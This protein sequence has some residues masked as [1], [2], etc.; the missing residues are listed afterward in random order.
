MS[1]TQATV[2]DLKEMLKRRGVRE[3]VYLHAD[4][5][6]PWSYRNQ[7]R[8]DINKENADNLAKFVEQTAAVDFARRL[9]LFY[10]AIV[11]YRM[12]TGA[13]CTGVPGDKMSFFMPNP[14]ENALARQAMGSLVNSSSHEIQAHYHHE[15]FVKNTKYT[16]TIEHSPKDRIE[17][18]QNESTPAM[19][20]ARFELG[21]QLLQRRIQEDTGLTFDRWF[22]VHGMWALNASDTDVC[23]ITNEIEIL[24]RNGFA[25]DFTFPAGRAHTNPLQVEPF[26]IRPIDAPKCYDR[27]DAEAEPAACAGQAKSDK[28]FIWASRAKADSCSIDYYSAGVKKRMTDTNQ[29]AKDLVE[30]SNVI[31]GVLYVKTHAHSM[32]PYYFEQARLPVFPHAHPEVQRLLGMILTAAA[33]TNLPIQ[34]LSASETYDK[35]LG[36][37]PRATSSA[38]FGAPR[39]DVSA[40]MASV[41]SAWPDNARARNEFLRDVIMQRVNQVGAVQAGVSEGFL[42]QVD[43]LQALRPYERD[44]VA[45]TVGVAADFPSIYVYKTALGVIPYA[46]ASLGLATTGVE[47]D[48]L[49]LET[50]RVLERAYNALKHPGVPFKVVGGWIG[51]IALPDDV[52]QSLA[53]LGDATAS[54]QPIEQLRKQIKALTEH[55]AVL[56]DAFRFLGRYASTEEHQN[57]RGLFE[58]EGFETPILILGHDQSWAFYLARRRQ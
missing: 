39:V 11:Y 45:A 29:W 52:G 42:K 17:F 36:V 49:R 1:N 19:D 22:F 10:R 30:G 6:E 25:G 50:A 14:E 43:Q 37:A 54:P 31:D 2:L 38:A 5:F 40:R 24:K 4:H 47:P 16:A 46:L 9:S 58:D 21:L 26:L 32:Y 51:A 18:L 12:G 41:T 56:F 53:V 3:F 13:D 57:V 20:C 8:N 44:L 15:Y 34:F 28:F 35:I 7:T 33:N 27:H 23:M 48:A 55:K